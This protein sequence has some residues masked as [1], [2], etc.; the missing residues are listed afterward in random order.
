MLNLTFLVNLLVRSLVNSQVLLPD[1]A[2][3][4]VTLQIR[5]QGTLG[6]KCLPGKILTG[7][8][9]S[10]DFTS[11]LGTLEAGLQT[12]SDFTDLLG[13]PKQFY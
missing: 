8:P 13:L 9:V 4:G 1:F 10:L 3:L 11:L 12:T 5:L 2:S 7:L 6:L